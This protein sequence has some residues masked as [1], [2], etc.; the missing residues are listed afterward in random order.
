MADVDGDGTSTCLSA[1]VSFR[2]ATPNPLHHCSSAV[3][4]A[5]SNWTSRIR[6]A[7]HTSASSA[8][9][10]SPIWMAMP[11]PILFWPANGVR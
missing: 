6:S 10:F 1:V 8:A 2:D 11:M 7:W 3:L 9:R 4:A 5:N